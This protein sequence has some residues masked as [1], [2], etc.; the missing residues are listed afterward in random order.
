M[1]SLPFFLGVVI[2]TPNE[3]AKKVFFFVQFSS[4]ERNRC[5]RS[6][7]LLLLIRVERQVVEADLQDRLREGPDAELGLYHFDRRR[8]L[9]RYLAKSYSIRFN[10][11]NLIM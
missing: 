5:G 1:F 9:L 11:F 4:E 7:G 3:L 2:T 6:H 8:A 10:Y